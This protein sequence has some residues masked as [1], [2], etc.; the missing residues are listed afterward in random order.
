M[1][2]EAGLEAEYM[3]PRSPCTL[4]TLEG[5][6]SG[7]N[8]RDLGR[9]PPCLSSG[10]PQPCWGFGCLFGVPVIGVWCAA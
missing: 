8:H 3:G 1:L 7:D 9:V 10:A 4:L 6:D 2:L 5:R